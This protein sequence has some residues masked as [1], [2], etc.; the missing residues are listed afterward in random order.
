MYYLLSKYPHHFISA[1]SPSSLN[2]ATKENRSHTRRL[3]IIGE[4]RCGDDQGSF[5][6]AV[7]C[8][9]VNPCAISGKVGNTPA[10]L[11]VLRV[12]EQHGTF[13]LLSNS[14]AEI[15]DGGSHKSST[16]AV[17]CQFSIV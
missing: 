7:A 11:L 3:I 1:P 9:T 2:L 5:T 8:G 6:Y 12:A 15:A 17:G 14:G 4:M 10:V 16:L 13:D